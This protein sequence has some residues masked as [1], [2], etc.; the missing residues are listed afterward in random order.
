MRVWDSETGECVQTLE[1][2][3]D[4]VNS[5]AWDP[6]GSG[7]MASASWDKTVRVWDAATG[8]CVS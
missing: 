3:T 5:V 1:G 4:A 6:S 8:A 7:R 2:H